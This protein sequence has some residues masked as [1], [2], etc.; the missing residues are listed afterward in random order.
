MFK[1]GYNGKICIV[2]FNIDVFICIC[3]NIQYYFVFFQFFWKYFEQQVNNMIKGDVGQNIFKFVSS[4]F[5]VVLIIIFMF[6]IFYVDL[7]DWLNII[8]FYVFVVVNQYF[9]L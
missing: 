5:E 1:I 7:V 8:Y 2:V 6:F 3:E 4:F 9:F